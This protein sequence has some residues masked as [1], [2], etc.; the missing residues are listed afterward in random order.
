MLLFI[1]S[2]ISPHR[3][4]VVFCFPY[5]PYLP[6]IWS[7]SREYGGKEE[8][9]CCNM[10]SLEPFHLVYV[11]SNLSIPLGTS[12]TKEVEGI[13]ASL[14]TKKSLWVSIFSVTTHSLA[15]TQPINPWFALSSL[16]K[17]SCVLTRNPFGSNFFRPRFGTRSFVAYIDGFLVCHIPKSLL[18]HCGPCSGGLGNFIS[19]SLLSLEFQKKSS[20][21]PFF[22]CCPVI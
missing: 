16:P 1:R 20:N 18:L 9:W 5:L 14:H 3:V 22:L 12:L 19:C 4:Q 2:L 7:Y 13:F 10:P 6:V 17:T 15:V 8:K 21:V 11:V